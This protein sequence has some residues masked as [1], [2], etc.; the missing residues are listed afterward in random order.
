M[1]RAIRRSGCTPFQGNRAAPRD[2]D[3]THTARTH[4]RFGRILSI[5]RGVSAAQQSSPL[6]SKLQHLSPT[7]FGTLCQFGMT[8]LGRLWDC[9]PILVPILSEAQQVS[10]LASKCRFLSLNLNLSLSPATFGTLCQLGR[11]ALGRLW[12]CPLILVPILSATRSRTWLVAGRC[13]VRA[14]CRFLPIKHFAGDRP[15]QT[16][17]AESTR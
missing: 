6:A 1:V 12:D 11:T 4:H 14:H 8:E 9:R 5:L 16:L 3:S 2:L 7:A 15:W 13:V 10:L 17:N